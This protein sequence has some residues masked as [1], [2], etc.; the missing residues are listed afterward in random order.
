MASLKLK[1]AIAH[2]K[3]SPFQATAAIFVL[4]LTFFVTTVLEILVYSSNNLIAH[5]E[6]RPQVIAFIKNDV[7]VEE[8]STLQN[9]LSNDERI[10]DVTYVSKEEALAIYK[11]ATSDNPLLSEL[12]SPT[13]FPASLEFSLADLSDAKNIINEVK[14]EEIVDQIGFTA[15]LG[16][17]STLEDV[18]ERLRT[19]TYYL[20]VG[21]GVFAGILFLT[22]FL[23]LTIIISMRMSARKGEI[24]ILNLIGATQKFVRGPIVLESLVYVAS[25][26]FIGW[27]FT[28]IIV[29]YLS[30][31]I[32]RYFVNRCF[33][34]K[35][36]TSSGAPFTPSP[37]RKK[38]RSAYSFLEPIQMYL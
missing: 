26:V 37:A 5:F 36:M 13:I 3:R 24:E 30:P 19:I 16:G 1:T 12:V 4:S 31:A 35:P 14:G 38:F 17:E 21:G 2:I 7:E 11:E 23:V 28:L 32:I 15:S 22:S 10:K 8:I 27:L 18:V 6:T 29:L 33:E 25:G 34:K 20:R 9:K